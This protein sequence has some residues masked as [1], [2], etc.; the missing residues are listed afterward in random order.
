MSD[1]VVVGKTQSR[2]FVARAWI[3]QM[4][5]GSGDSVINMHFDQ[6]IEVTIR[7]KETGKS[8]TLQP[9]VAL[10][11]FPNQ[12]RDGKKDADLRFSFLK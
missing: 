11:G 5:D 7:D 3:N 1:V 2:E 10:T 4:K 8:Y 12:K 9:G 6:H